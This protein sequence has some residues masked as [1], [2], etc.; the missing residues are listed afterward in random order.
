M[1]RLHI[2][3]GRGGGELHLLEGDP[4]ALFIMKPRYTVLSSLL[5]IY[6]VFYTHFYLDSWMLSLD[7]GLQSG[8]GPFISMLQSF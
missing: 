5:V 3:T 2:G 7:F 8:L 4:N 1:H 6:S